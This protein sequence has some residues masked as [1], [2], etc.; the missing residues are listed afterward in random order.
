MFWTAVATS[1]PSRL[2]SSI[3]SGENEAGSRRTTWPWSTSSRID[4]STGRAE[5]GGNVVSEPAPAAAITWAAPSSASTIAV[6]SK[7]TSPRSS[8]MNAPKAWSRSSEEPSARAQRYGLDRC[9][10]DGEGDRADDAVA[11]R[12]LHDHDQEQPPD[13]RALLEVED[14]DERR[15]EDGVEGERPGP[16]HGL[17]TRPQVAPRER[18]DDDRSEREHSGG[19]PGVLGVA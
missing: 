7:G 1:R 4:P 18:E 15:D 13:R 6:R 9:V 11:N 5:P 8:R 17:R 3:S 10:R 12:R 19:Q 16:Q 14:E 2:T